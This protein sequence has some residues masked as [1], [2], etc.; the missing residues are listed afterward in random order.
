MNSWYDYWLDC[1]VYHRRPISQTR[2]YAFSNF[3]TNSNKVNKV[4]N[5][6]TRYRRGCWR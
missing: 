1:Y 4:N 5:K 2:Q 3:R 6:Y